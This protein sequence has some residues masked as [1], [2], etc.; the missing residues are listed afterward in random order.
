MSP[1]HELEKWRFTGQFKRVRSWV[2]IRRFVA[3]YNSSLQ[4]TVN[5]RIDNNNYF[6]FVSSIYF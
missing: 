2:V 5:F 3:I 1:T 4:T 6:I